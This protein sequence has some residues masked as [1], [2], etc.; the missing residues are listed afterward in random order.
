MEFAY[1]FVRDDI[2]F[3]A[4]NRPPNGKNERTLRRR[5]RK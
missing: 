3:V 4:N 1:P 2:F 5:R